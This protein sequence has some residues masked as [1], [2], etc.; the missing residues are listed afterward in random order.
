MVDRRTRY[1]ISN[2]KSYRES[3]MGS[4]QGSAPNPSQLVDAV[5]TMMTAPSPKSTVRQNRSTSTDNNNAAIVAN[6]RREPGSQPIV[7]QTSNFGS[8]MVYRMTSRAD[9][10]LPMSNPSRPRYKRRYPENS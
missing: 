1:Y 4:Y 9:D 7:K 5:G 8:S 6:T 2:R 3:R 10:A